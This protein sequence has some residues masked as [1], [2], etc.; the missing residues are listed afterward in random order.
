MHGVVYRS[1]M[2]P[3]KKLLISRVR[4]FSLVEVVI[5]LGVVSFTILS[6]ISLLPM[7]LAT[8]RDAS[9]IYYSSQARQQ[10]LDNLEQIPTSS[11]VTLLNG[12]TSFTG[13]YYFDG[14]GGFL[15]TNSPTTSATAKDAVYQDVFTVSTLKTPLGG[16]A[17]TAIAI[18]TD[19]ASVGTLNNSIVVTT[20]FGRYLPAGVTPP[21]AAIAAQEG[22]S[23]FRTATDY[24]FYKKPPQ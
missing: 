24:L 11:M 7:G 15:G 18:P 20:Q 16:E 1:L 5:A 6:M 19:T 2:R 3:E 23:T 21:D 8:F 14:Q 9:E 12:G 13:T 22:N 17:S 10:I 4:A